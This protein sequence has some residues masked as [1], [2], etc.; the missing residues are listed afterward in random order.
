[1]LP[2][3]L[4]ATARTSLYLGGTTCTPLS[5]ANVQAQCRSEAQGT[6][7]ITAH[8]A[9]VVQH[10]EGLHHD[11]WSAHVADAVAGGAGMMP[12]LNPVPLGQRPWP[13]SNC[14]QVDG[15]DDRTTRK[16]GLAYETL[17]STVEM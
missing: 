9:H 8:R 3:P 16:S 14:R 12:K 11:G 10:A 2:C 6:G 1:M 17:M 5:A 7:S 13:W 15:A 4:N